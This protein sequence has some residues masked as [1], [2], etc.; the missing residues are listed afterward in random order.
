MPFSMDVSGSEHV[1]VSRSL[2]HFGQVM[3]SKSSPLF[4][5]GTQQLDLQRDGS[6]S[7]SQGDLALIRNFE[8]MI[9]I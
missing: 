5:A 4:M 6:G 9:D 2:C 8:Q 1:E 7:K 3:G